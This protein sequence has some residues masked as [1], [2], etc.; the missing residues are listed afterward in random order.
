LPPDHDINPWTDAQAAEARKLKLQSEHPGLLVP[1]VVNEKKSEERSNSN[2]PELT[3]GPGEAIDF[4]QDLRY[5]AAEEQVIGVD[6]RKKSL[7]NDSQR[8]VNQQFWFHSQQP[9]TFRVSLTIAN[10]RVRVRPEDLVHK[11]QSLLFA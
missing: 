11:T 9:T 10:V 8:V 3:P 1:L 4:R 2:S 7:C 6:L 5:R